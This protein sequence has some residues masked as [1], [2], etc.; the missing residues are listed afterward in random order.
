MDTL[1]CVSFRDEI[2]ICGGRYNND[3][4]SYHIVKQEYKRICSYPSEIR[5]FGHKVV[6]YTSHTDTNTVTIISFGGSFTTSH[7]LMM[8]YQSVW[9]E[10][11]PPIQNANENESQSQVKAKINKWIPLPNRLDLN[12]GYVESRYVGA[13]VSGSNNEFLFITRKPHTIDVVDL[14][15]FTY[16]ESHI[17]EPLIKWNYLEFDD[18]SVVP[19][20]NQKKQFVI[21]NEK[22]NWLIQFNEKSKRFSYNT[23][24][25]CFFLRRHHRFSC[26]RFHNQIFV[27]GGYSNESYKLTNQICVY[28]T[29]EYYWSKCPLPMPR[30]LADCAVVANYNLF[31]LHVIGG[32]G[33]LQSHD[34]HFALIVLSERDI[35]QMIEYWWKHS[36]GKPSK[37][38]RDIGELIVQY[39]T[40]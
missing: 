18:H 31:S 28:N 4:Y 23:L 1:Q 17:E 2:L 16:L 24:P 25:E 15:S 37:W 13:V 3:C 12:K 26:C 21:V 20:N 33:N 5:L 6:S 34:S 8:R 7:N 39:L 19:L 14:R 38:V 11:S 36:G 10:L 32:V 30:N 27:V 35:Q 40:N 29:D 9:E 22:K